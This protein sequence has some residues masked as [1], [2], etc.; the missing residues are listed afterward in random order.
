MKANPK[1]SVFMKGKTWDI[2]SWDRTITF[3]LTGAITK[4]FFQPVVRV[5]KMLRN[6]D[7]EGSVDCIN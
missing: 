4:F 1:S 5:Q 6:T 2:I 3:F 7:L